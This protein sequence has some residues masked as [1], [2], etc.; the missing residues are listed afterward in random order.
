MIKKI[1]VAFDGS[2]PSQHAFDFASELAYHFKAKLLLLAV[3]RLPEP[4]T[5]LELGAVLDDA[6]QHYAKAFEELRDRTNPRGIE[7]TTEVEVGHPAEHIVAKAEKE[8]YD[9]V[10][11]GRRG[12]TAVGRFVLGSTSERVLRYAHCAVTIVK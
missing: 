11:M 3:V 8:H 10:V 12:R 4:T 1:L 5:S 6:K 2:E 7:F 9:L